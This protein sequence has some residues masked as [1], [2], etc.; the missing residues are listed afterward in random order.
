MKKIISIFSVLFF[1]MVSSVASAEQVEV[2]Y[3]THE[4]FKDKV[5]EGLVAYRLATGRSAKVVTWQDLVAN[6]EGYDDIEKI[7][8]GLY[9]LRQSTNFQHLVL[10]GDGDVVPTPQCAE[11]YPPVSE[12]SGDEDKNFVHVIN[13]LTDCNYSIF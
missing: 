9:A 10:A 7:R 2:V 1:L 13:H 12:D 3:L 4:Y 5:E 11:W 6:N 8:K